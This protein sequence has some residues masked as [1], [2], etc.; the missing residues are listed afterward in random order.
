MDTAEYVLIVAPGIVPE[1]KTKKIVLIDANATEREFEIFSDKD[2]FWVNDPKQPVS[3]VDVESMEKYAQ[4]IEMHLWKALRQV[5]NEIHETEISQQ[6]WEILGGHWVRT[7]S[8]AISYRK[9]QVERCIEIFGENI[10]FYGFDDSMLE[11]PRDTASAEKIFDD[12]ICNSFIYKKLIGK[13]AS[14]FKYYQ[15]LVENVKKK[16]I[17][18]KMTYEPSILEKFNGKIAIWFETIA[19]RFY[20]NSDALILNTYLPFWSEIRLSLALHQL[21]RFPRFSTP[22]TNQKTS[23]SLRSKFLEL[24][25]LAI[26]DIETRRVLEIFVKLTPQSLLE[27]RANLQSFAKKVPF[28]KSPR[29][30]FT[31]N[32]F[33]TDE[34]FKAWTVQKIAQGVPYFVGQ[35][36]NNYGVNRFL[37]PSVEEL[38]ATRFLTWGWENHYSTPL[39]VLKQPNPKIRSSKGKRNNL[40]II[41]NSKE[42][43]ISYWD[44]KAYYLRN[45]LEQSNL[46]SQL[47]PQIRQ[48]VLF[49]LHHENSHYQNLLVRELITRLDATQFDFGNRSLKPLIDKSKLVVYAY[50]STGILECLAR[51]IPTLGIWSA[52]IDYLMPWVKPLY[53]EMFAAEIF[54][55]DSTK[56][57]EKI[58]EVWADVDSW[59]SSPKIQHIRQDFCNN[60]ARS[61]SSPVTDI[62][63]TIETYK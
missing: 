57:A 11:P 8:R 46:L 56:L 63:N 22:K 10:S 50:D 38:T 19:V 18:P 62:L 33:M 25:Q 4:G 27:D 59:W 1:Q 26:Q 30:I 29:F 15:V 53:E 13:Y 41:Q 5:L 9:H 3:P 21:P 60:L 48:K 55:C 42:P 37:S 58:N 45:A 54:F 36:G 52:D 47:H 14:K 32:N 31:S 28:P 40:L 51:N 17:S 44:S 49:R 61:S 39:F 35:H 24:L 20:G 43:Q 16:T 34:I 7:F 6:G 2:S 23:E 12:T